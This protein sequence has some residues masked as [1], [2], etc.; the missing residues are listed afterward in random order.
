MTE[1]IRQY[2][3]SIRCICPGCPAVSGKDGRI[4]CGRVADC[5]VN[6]WHHVAQRKELDKI[7][8][9]KGW[10]RLKTL[11]VFQRLCPRCCATVL[12]QRAAMKLKWG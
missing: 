4:K 9:Q 5:L 6:E 11:G 10:K 1:K 8:E 7:L 12:K 3:T 2:A